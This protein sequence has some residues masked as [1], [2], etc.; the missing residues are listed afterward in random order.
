MSGR[1]GSHA[2]DCV[3]VPRPGVLHRRLEDEAVLL[4]P[5]SGTYYALNEVGSRVWDLAADHPTLGEVVRVLLAEYEVEAAT[6]R[7]DLDALLDQLVE[8][9]L[10]DV[11]RR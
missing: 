10:L 3:L 8:E 5:K 9:G 2:D 6:L 1:S 4:D 11:E 7:G